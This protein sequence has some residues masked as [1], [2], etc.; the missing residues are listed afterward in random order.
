MNHTDIFSKNG[1]HVRGLILITLIFSVKKRDTSKRSDFNHTDIF[2]KK[3][4][5]QIRDLI[6][7]N[8]TDLFNKERGHK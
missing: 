7:I 8:L 5:A 1:A 4:G 6:L 2:S 3:E